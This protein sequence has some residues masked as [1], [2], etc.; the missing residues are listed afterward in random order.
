MVMSPAQWLT[1]RRLVP[2]PKPLRADPVSANSVLAG[3]ASAQVPEPTNPHGMGSLCQRPSGFGGH[4]RRLHSAH[5][6]VS[7]GALDEMRVA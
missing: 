5:K 1:A 7:Q 4:F 6:P 3:N 2:S